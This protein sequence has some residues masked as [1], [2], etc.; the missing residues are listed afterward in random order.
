MRW[1]PQLK[2]RAVAVMFAAAAAL[3]TTAAPAAANGLVSVGPV[4]VVE[5]TPAGDGFVWVKLN[6]SVSC[7]SVGGPGPVTSV[8][9]HQGANFQPYEGAM[10]SK[11]FDII[12]S[13]LLS[14]QLAGKTIWLLVG[15][16]G[17]TGGICFIERVTLD[18]P[19]P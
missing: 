10:T 8:M 6:T 11:G 18:T 17:E 14:A 19:A 1:K 2:L 5:L 9:L 16:A 7:A 13:A 4:R 12:F 3:F 15:P